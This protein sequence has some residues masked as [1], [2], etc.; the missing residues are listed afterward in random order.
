MGRMMKPEW[1]V[2]AEEEQ[3]QLAGRIKALDAA[4]SRAD[5][6]KSLTEDDL[7]DLCDQQAAMHN[8]N[9][10]LSCRIKRNGGTVCE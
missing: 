3:T 9:A 6:V 2:R 4:L 10:A 8:Y 5:F 1:L 7:T